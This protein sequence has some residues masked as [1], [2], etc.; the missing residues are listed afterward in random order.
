MDNLVG[1]DKGEAK[2]TERPLCG[3]IQKAILALGRY[4]GVLELGNDKV[5]LYVSCVQSLLHLSA[6]IVY[7]LAITENVAEF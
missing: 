7:P 1:T 4:P 5:E 6:G 2:T 3:L